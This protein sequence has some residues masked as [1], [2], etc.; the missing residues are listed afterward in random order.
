MG[1]FESLENDNFTH[2]VSKIW[3]KVANF[4]KMKGNKMIAVMQYSKNHWYFC[5]V[6]F[7]E[8][9][10]FETGSRISRVIFINIT[11]N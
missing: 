6:E 3:S 8:F 2:K 4:F 1:I 7:D 11:H 9:K 5:I 10:H